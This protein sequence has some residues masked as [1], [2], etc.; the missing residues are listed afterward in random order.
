MIIEGEAYGD[1]KYSDP[2]PNMKGWQDADYYALCLH[3][4]C[5][6]NSLS[7][8]G[9]FR[10]R[11]MSMIE[12]KARIWMCIVR[13]TAD[14]N[15]HNSKNRASKRK[16]TGGENPSVEEVTDRHPSAGVFGDTQDN[17]STL[18]KSH[19]QVQHSSPQSPRLSSSGLIKLRNR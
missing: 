1:G 19:K 2:D 5:T 15:R 11:Q 13:A 4:L 12:K 17:A 6:E 8:N 16:S 7:H 9:L 3:R 10:K 14:A 18:K